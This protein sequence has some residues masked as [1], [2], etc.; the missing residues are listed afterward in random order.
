MLSTVCSLRAVRVVKTKKEREYVAS[1]GGLFLHLIVGAPGRC[2]M[3]VF[4]FLGWQA[5]HVCVCV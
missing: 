2:D 4:S 1:G 5:L 3:F